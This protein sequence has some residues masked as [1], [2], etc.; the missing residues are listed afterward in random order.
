MF[1][2]IVLFDDLQ[3]KQYQRHFHVFKPIQWRGEVEILNVETHVLSTFHAKDAIPHQFRYGKICC[4]CGQFSRI[5]NEIS[6]S[7]YTSSVWV[8]LL[9]TEINDDANIC[10]CLSFGD[11]SL[12][13]L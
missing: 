4:L 9:R 8:F 6:A 12:I 5:M 7:C 1:G 2:E 13:S 3:W 10:N 11:D